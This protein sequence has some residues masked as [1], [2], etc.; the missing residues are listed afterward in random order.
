MTGPHSH[1]GLL[2]PDDIKLLTWWQ[3][4]WTWPSSDGEIHPTQWLETQGFHFL[5]HYPTTAACL[6][7]PV[8]TLRLVT[9]TRYRAMEEFFPCFLFQSEDTMQFLNWATPFSLL[10]CWYRATGLKCHWWFLHLWFITCNR[11]KPTNVS[12]GSVFAAR[13]GKSS[14]GLCVLGQDR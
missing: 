3:Q 5:G 10:S 13:L 8:P 7:H 14:A 1:L 9:S 11:T 12:Q 2:R 4:T 6:M